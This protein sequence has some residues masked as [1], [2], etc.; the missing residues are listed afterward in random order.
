MPNNGGN[1]DR[2]AARALL[3][4][5]ASE[6]LVRASA[7]TGRFFGRRVGLCAIINIHSGGCAMDCAFCSQNAKGLMDQRPMQMDELEKR[8]LALAATP[9]SHIGLVA[10]GGVIGEKLF[11]KLLEFFGQCPESIRNKICVS[12]GRLD[13]EKLRLL[14]QAGIRRYHHNLETSEKFYPRICHTQKWSDRKKTIEG[15]INAGLEPCCGGLF[16]MGET[17]ADRAELAVTLGELGV[18]EV[19]INFL[20][21]RPGTALASRSGPETKE[22]L[23]ILALFRN[24]LPRA[25]LRVCGGRLESLG[26]RQKDMF[27]AGASALMTGDYLTTK[28]VALAEDLAMLRELNREAD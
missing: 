15:A 5:P 24:I 20:N 10:S 26:N 14:K 4:I 2:A 13:P 9:V 27:G 17:W 19:P 3:G 7:L 23:R 6:L 1:G 22:A 11:G 18:R 21:P 28:G 25:N 12:F 16:G 8:L